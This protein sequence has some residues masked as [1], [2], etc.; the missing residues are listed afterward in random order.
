M[1]VAGK[2][3]T[4]KQVVNELDAVLMKRVADGRPYGHPVSGCLA[5]R[6]VGYPGHDPC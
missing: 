5:S 6:A 4:R 1:F 3:E 2:G